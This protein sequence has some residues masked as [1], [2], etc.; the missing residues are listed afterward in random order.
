MVCDALKLRELELESLEFPELELGSLELRELELVSLELRE[1]ELVA[2]VP[3]GYECTHMSVYSMHIDLS[4][5][6]YE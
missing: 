2:H 6:M 4:V 1:L 3:Y 5:C